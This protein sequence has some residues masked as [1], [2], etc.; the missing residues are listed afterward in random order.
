M[1]EAASFT[2]A[3]RSYWGKGHFSFPESLWQIDCKN[4]PNSPFLPYHGQWDLVVS[5]YYQGVGSLFLTVCSLNRGCLVT[6]FAQWNASAKEDICKNNKGLKI[7]QYLSL[8]GKTNAAGV[9][10]HQFQA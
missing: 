7:N 4:G 1:W 9:M 8:K 10:V 5:S 2:S 6:Y 3:L